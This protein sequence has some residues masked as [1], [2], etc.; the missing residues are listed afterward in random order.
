M[1]V[2]TGPSGRASL[3]EPA[4]V[5]LGCAA[6]AARWV[7]VPLPPPRSRTAGLQNVRGERDIHTMCWSQSLHVADGKRRFAGDRAG[8]G[9]VPGRGAT[10]LV[11]VPTQPRAASCPLHSR[12]RPAHCTL[13]C[14]QTEALSGQEQQ[15]RTGMPR[16][17]SAE[18]LGH[19]PRAART[20]TGPRLSTQGSAWLGGGLL[21]TKDPGPK[22]EADSALR[23]QAVRI[24]CREHHCEAW[25]VRTHELLT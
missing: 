16:L 24:S 23:A 5:T 8:P 25:T 13:V 22:G 4:S 2:G 15:Q 14:E 1:S 20:R 7:P 11:L 3:P 6:D 18:L 10:L 9:S 17:A 19:S 21:G 12:L